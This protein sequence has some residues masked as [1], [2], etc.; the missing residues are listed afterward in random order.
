MKYLG[1]PLS[2]TRL[3]RIHFQPLEDKVAAKLLPWIGKHVTMAG[4]STL[5]K[6]VLTSIAI[7]YITVLNVPVEVLMKIDSIRRAFLWAASDKVTGGKCKVSWDMVCKPKEYGGLGILNLAKFAS[8]LRMRW[9]W[10]E[11]SDEARPWVGLGNPCNNQ[12]KELFA[13]ATKISIGNGKKAIF[14]EDPWLDGKRP[15]DIAP[16]VYKIS[17]GKRC[18]VGKALDANFWISKINTNDGLTLEHITQ[19]ATLWEMIQPVQLNSNTSDSISWKLTNSGCYSSKSAYNMQFLGHTKSSFPSLV[20][21]PWAPPKC[22]T[23]AWLIIQNRVWT[24]DR[25][26]KRGWPNCGRCKLCNQVH[27]SASHLLFKCR[28][29]IGV[30]SSVRSWLGLHD[31]DPSAWHS[32]GNVK[33]WWTEEIHKPRQG[34]KAMASLAMLISWEIWKERNARVFRNKASTTD[35]VITKIKDEVAMWSMAGAK[36]LSNVIPRE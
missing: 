29:T 30:W 1:L 10:H 17:Q 25:L 19:F 36:A 18:S 4:R 13:A 34:R 27:E 22:K 3:K 23:F 7:Y 12:D 14:W 28:F 16:L 32:R 15:K 21:K 26:Q 33:E 2:V 6:Y 9:L 8:A 11:W 24:A 20:W 5:V 31:V 35:M